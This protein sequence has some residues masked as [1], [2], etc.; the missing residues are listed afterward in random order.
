M[1]PQGHLRTPPSVTVSSRRLSVW[2]GGE[3]VALRHY[4]DKNIMLTGKDL[5]I[6]HTAAESLLEHLEGQGW[7]VISSDG[8]QQLRR[9][10]PSQC[11][12]SL[13]QQTADSDEDSAESSTVEWTLQLGPHMPY[14]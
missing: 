6:L 9:A 8:T 3:G 2:K 10:S 4:M 13:N 14:Y 7:V 11:M 5:A 1:W 12:S